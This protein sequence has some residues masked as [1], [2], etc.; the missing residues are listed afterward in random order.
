MDAFEGRL[1]KGGINSSQDKIV[2]LQDTV[3][4][5]LFI[6]YNIFIFF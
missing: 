4:V 1:L 3:L 2:R 5:L 6:C